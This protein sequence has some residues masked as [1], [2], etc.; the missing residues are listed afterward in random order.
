MKKTLNDD[1]LPLFLQL[2]TFKK[3][4]KSDLE[5]NLLTSNKYQSDQVYTYSFHKPILF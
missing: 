3:N 2:G 1:T 5:Q 4:I